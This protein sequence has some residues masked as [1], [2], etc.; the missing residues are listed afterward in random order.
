MATRD[1]IFC[2][3]LLLRKSCLCFEI[4]RVQDRQSACNLTLRSV[5]GN[6][7]CSEKS[8]SIA[9]S[10][11]VFVALSIEHAMRMRHIVVCDLSGS[12]IFFSTLSHKRHNFRQNLL[13]IKCAFWFSLQLL[14]AIFLILGRNE[15]DMIKNAYWSS[16]KAPFILVRF[17]RDLNFFRHN[18]A[19]K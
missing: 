2:E 19:H 1:P 11:C 12:A 17:Y 15:R 6:D 16:C 9:Y 4:L 5:R 13:N 8:I 3:L 7:R 10:E 14:V 18:F